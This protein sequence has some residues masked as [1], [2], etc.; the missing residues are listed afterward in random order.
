MD[1]FKDKIPYWHSLKKT[2]SN[3]IV[4]SMHVWL[5]LVPITAKSLSL[6]EGPFIITVSDKVYAFDISLPFTWTLFF[7]SALFFTL[8]NI[9]FICFSPKIIKENDDLS[10]FERAGKDEGHLEKYFSKSLMTEWSRFLLS[11]GQQFGQYKPKINL[12][13]WF[14]KA[15]DNQNSSLIIARI[16]C[17]SFYALGF[18]LIII[19]G[20]QNIWWVIGQVNF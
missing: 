7:G 14:W 6:I 16:A 2:E 11:Q 12:K 5:I 15:Y 19:I 4:Q 17:S 13:E 18:I 9:I 8:A 20:I 3:K 1:K 10:D